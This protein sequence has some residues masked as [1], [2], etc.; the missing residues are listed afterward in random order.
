MQRLLQLQLQLLRL[1]QQQHAV[2]LLSDREIV[3]QEAEQQAELV[4]R[5]GHA[6]RD[7]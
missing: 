3:V 1:E 2:N 7:T 6:L 5:C 4:R